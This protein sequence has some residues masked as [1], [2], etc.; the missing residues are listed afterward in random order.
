E[1]ADYAEPGITPS[2]V[3]DKFAELYRRKHI[4]TEDYSGHG[5]GLEPRE[6]P[7]MGLG[8]PKS[9]HDGVISTSTDL[10]LEPGMVISLETSI[11]EP[12]EGSYEVER[13][14]LVG[15]SSLKELTTKKDSAI[16]VTE[17]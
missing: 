6:Y 14:F 17:A 1:I 15:R 12:G 7:I 9:I 2:A 5:I 13:T 8:G 10:P 16:F 3:M 4:S 11:Y